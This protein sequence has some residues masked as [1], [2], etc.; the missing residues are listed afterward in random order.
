[1]KTRIHESMRN[2]QDKYKSAKELKEFTPEEK[3]RYKKSFGQAAALVES[4]IPAELLAKRV[5]EALDSGQQYIFTHPNYKEATD[6]RAALIGKAFNDAE[7]S[8]LVKHLIGD[9]MVSL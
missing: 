1:M 2:K 9:D 6:Y 7:Q 3:E 4:G 5:V 8:D